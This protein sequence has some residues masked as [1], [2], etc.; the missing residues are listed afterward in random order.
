MNE[1]K[2]FDS[3][4]TVDTENEPD[5]EIT[6]DIFYVRYYLKKYFSYS[7][8]LPISEFRYVDA[9]IKESIV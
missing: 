1:E 3:I 6:D 9:K 7:Y 5:I 8:L 2:N 4:I